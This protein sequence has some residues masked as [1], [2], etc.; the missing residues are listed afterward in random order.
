MYRYES[1]VDWVLVRMIEKEIRDGLHDDV[2]L[3]QDSRMP[4]YGTRNLGPV[5]DVSKN[6]DRADARHA[7]R[8]GKGYRK[9]REP[10]LA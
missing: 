9:K 7:Y 4:R 6:A 5:H 10:S 8:P 2:L 1:N 3:R